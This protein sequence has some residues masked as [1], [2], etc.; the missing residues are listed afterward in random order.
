MMRNLF[1]LFVSKLTGQADQRF[2]TIRLAIIAAGLLATSIPGSPTAQAAVITF[3]AGDASAPPSSPVIVPIAVNDFTDVLLFQFTIQWDPGVVQF[4]SIANLAN[5]PGFAVGNFGTGNAGMGQLT[6]SWDDGDLSGEDLAN[7]SKLFDI[8]FTTI[9][10]VGS[11]TLVQ[12]T[13]DPTPRLVGINVGG[14]PTPAGFFPDDGSVTVV[15]EPVNAAL[16]LFGTLLAGTGIVRWL[17]GRQTTRE[18][19]ISNVSGD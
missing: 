15:P 11:S 5:L 3:T 12:F 16:G 2:H 7:G 9:G 17:F 18:Y 6:V 8:N 10:L 4:S 14:T 13:D 1:N 19:L